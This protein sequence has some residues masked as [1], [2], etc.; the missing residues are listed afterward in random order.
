MWGFIMNIAACGSGERW[1][2]LKQIPVHL[3]TLT[4]MANHS[5]R[6]D[7]DSDNDFDD[8]LDDRK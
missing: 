6:D 3:I 8:G 7:D 1:S 2:K 4:R 5:V